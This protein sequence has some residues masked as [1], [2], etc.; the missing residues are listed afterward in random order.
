MGD[1][2]GFENDAKPPEG[3]ARK[4]GKFVIFDPDQNHLYPRRADID[5]RE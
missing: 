5:L 1:F 3:K 2:I 4:F